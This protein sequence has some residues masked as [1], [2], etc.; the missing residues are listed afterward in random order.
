MCASE[1]QRSSKWQQDTQICATLRKQALVANRE[2]C[3]DKDVKPHLIS[4]RKPPHTIEAHR[5][6]TPLCFGAKTLRPDARRKVV[7]KQ[8]RNPASEATTVPSGGAQDSTQR[9]VP[10]RGLD[11][12]PGAPERA[13]NGSE[14]PKRPRLCHRLMVCP[15]K[16]HKREQNRN[17]DVLI[18][19]TQQTSTK[20]SKSARRFGIG[21]L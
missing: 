9:H 6:R 14:C 17:N 11:T 4:L 13:T 7:A 8:H 16:E 2:A 12:H 21:H 18:C 1:R 3:V 5:N 19:K 20:P 15:T 10:L